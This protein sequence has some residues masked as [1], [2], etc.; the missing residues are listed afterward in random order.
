MGCSLNYQFK[1]ILCNNKLLINRN[2]RISGCRS[3]P[4]GITSAFSLVMT[5]PAVIARSVAPK[6]V[7]APVLS[8]V[9]GTSEA[10]P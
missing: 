6:N 9:E 10:T 4:K 3:N 7:I 5:M 2:F 1:C 8:A